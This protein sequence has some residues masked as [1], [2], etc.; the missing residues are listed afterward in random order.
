VYGKTSAYSMTADA[1]I[2]V[3]ANYG[4][5]KLPQGESRS[6]GG[7]FDAVFCPTGGWRRTRPGQVRPRPWEF[8]VEGLGGGSILYEEELWTARLPYGQHRIGSWHGTCLQGETDRHKWDK[9]APTS[10][11]TIT[12]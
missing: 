9:V 12:W 6:G 11:G 5:R 3:P 2:L 8:S 1:D 10:V 4:G 7:N